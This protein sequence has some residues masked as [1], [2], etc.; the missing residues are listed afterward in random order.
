M[1]QAQT[2]RFDAD[3]LMLARSVLSDG[4]FAVEVLEADVMMLLAE[5]RHFVVGVVATSTINHLLNAESL[6]FEALETR[7]STSDLGSKKWDAYLVMLT[8]ERAS[9]DDAT[10]R[11]LF[12]INHDTSHMR[13]M[14]H[15]DVELTRAS[16]ARALS[17]FLEPVEVN[18]SDTRSDALM[19]LVQALIRRGIPESLAMKAITVFNQG[20]A[21]DDVL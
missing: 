19:T 14:A 11:G 21:L 7:I 2:P 15:T 4:G 1:M 18:E 5:N 6:V 13:R 17:A 8:Q 20:G 9:D 12:A 16:V 10:T 3:L